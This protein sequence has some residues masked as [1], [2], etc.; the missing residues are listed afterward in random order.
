MA[1]ITD[2]DELGQHFFSWARWRVSGDPQPVE[3]GF[4]RP[5]TP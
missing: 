5:T 3:E 1:G 2:N 4:R